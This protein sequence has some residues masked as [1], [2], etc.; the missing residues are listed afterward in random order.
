[1]RR[2]R[3]LP[4][5]L[6]P[7][8]PSGAF[9]EVENALRDPNGLLAI[10]GDLSVRRL[11]NAYRHG[12]FPWYNPSD[13]ILWWSPDPRTLLIPEDLHISRSLRKKLRRRHYALSMDRDFPRVINAC[14]GISRHGETGTWLL[15]EMIRAYRALNIHGIAHSVEVWE[16]AQL[17]GGLY[18]VAI[19]RAFFGESMFSLATDASKVALVFLCQR[20]SKWGFDFIDCQMVTQH[21]LHMGA[22]S[23]PRETF[24][25]KLEACRD[26]AGQEGSWDDGSLHYPEPPH[27]KAQPAP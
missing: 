1:M 27:S 19:G 6:S 7:N 13:P 11:I 17:A 8:D 24:I 26:L 22:R 21:L 15:P 25:Q 16:G 5:L 18:G 2:P 14:A 4:Y 10:G 23:V 12:I 20:L 3:S 9:P